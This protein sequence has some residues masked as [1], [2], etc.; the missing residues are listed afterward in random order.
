MI[1][2]RVTCADVYMVTLAANAD[3]HVHTHTPTDSATNSSTTT[4]TT[5]LSS[6]SLWIGFLSLSSPANEGRP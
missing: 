1:V 5:H 4:T 3:S 6:T 2:P